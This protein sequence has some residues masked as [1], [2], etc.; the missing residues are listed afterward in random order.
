MN[1]PAS[2]YRLLAGL[3]AAQPFDSVLVGDASLSRRPMRRVTGPLAQMG[4]RMRALDHPDATG[5]L[6]RLILE[7]IPKPPAVATGQ[8][9][10]DARREEDDV[11][12]A[13]R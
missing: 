12:A 1:R 7:P 4:A 9:A 8:G 5:R 6:V 3:L 10:R 2:P 13:V 11:L